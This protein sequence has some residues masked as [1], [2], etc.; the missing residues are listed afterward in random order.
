MSELNTSRLAGLQEYPSCPEMT[1]PKCPS[2]ACPTEAFPDIEK[3]LEAV[4]SNVTCP[5][6]PSLT[7]PTEA[8]PDIEKRLEAVVSKVTCPA[9][10]SL[11]CPDIAC[12]EVQCPEVQCPEEKA[13][14]DI[15]KSL[16]AILSNFNFSRVLEKSETSANGGQAHHGC[17]DGLEPTV[18]EKQ[19]EAAEDYMDTCDCPDYSVLYVLLATFIVLLFIDVCLR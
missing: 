18:T 10:P 2:L 16:L 9:C 13:F 12:P 3:R 1:C 17:P 6:C 7:C 4:V 15:E 11:T 14:P 19:I 8:L 5:V